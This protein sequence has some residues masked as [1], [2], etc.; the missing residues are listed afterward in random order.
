M[1]IVLNPPNRF[2]HCFFLVFFAFYEKNKSYTYLTNLKNMWYNNLRSRMFSKGSIPV[3]IP[4]FTRG[5]Y[6]FRPLKD[7]VEIPKINGKEIVL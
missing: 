3:E 1:N 6:K 5:T 4:D 7:V 2:N